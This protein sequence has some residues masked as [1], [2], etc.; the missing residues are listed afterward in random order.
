MTARI[1]VADAKCPCCGMPG[2]IKLTDPKNERS[3][4]KQKRCYF[5][6]KASWDGGCVGRFQGGH[7]KFEKW[8][9][10]HVTKWRDDATR[11]RLGFGKGKAAEPEP[12]PDPAPESD[13]RAPAPKAP[14]Q[15]I[16]DRE[17]F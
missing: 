11:E 12:E 14:K 4:D 17:L 10:G 7:E 3:K 16:W 6:C 9:V 8:L 1:I 5:Y 15:S 2:Q 13:D